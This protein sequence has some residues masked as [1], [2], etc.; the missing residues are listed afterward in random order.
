MA[1]ENPNKEE[2]L[3]RV[4]H[5]VAA[6]TVVLPLAMLLPASAPPHDRTTFPAGENSHAQT[7][8]VPAPSEARALQKHGSYASRHVYAG[9]DVTVIVGETTQK[10]RQRRTAESGQSP[11]K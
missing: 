8:A 9:R 11:S 2:A 3:N 7:S 4:A 1:A 10:L 5:G 6:A